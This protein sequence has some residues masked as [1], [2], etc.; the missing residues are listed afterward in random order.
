MTIFNKSR[1]N[2]VGHVRKGGPWKQYWMLG[3]RCTIVIQTFCVCW[4]IMWRTPLLL[5]WQFY[6]TN[7]IL[8]T[9]IILTNKEGFKLEKIC[10][11]HYSNYI[12]LSYCL[13]IT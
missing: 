2:L 13:I 12:M 4:V 6:R 3:R 10:L 8:S 11:I 7:F 5:L 9:Y 1:Q